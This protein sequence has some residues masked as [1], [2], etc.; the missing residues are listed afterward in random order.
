MYIYIYNNIYVYYDRQGE[1]TWEYMEIHKF[2][3]FFWRVRSPKV[4]G[5]VGGDT[6]L[7]YSGG[8]FITTSHDI[9]YTLG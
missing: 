1:I 6:E 4:S 8:R 7:S 3:F 9:A 5:P 2:L